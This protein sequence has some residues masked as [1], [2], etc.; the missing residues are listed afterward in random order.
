M[1]ATAMVTSATILF[2][3]EEVSSRSSTRRNES[4][5]SS[6]R[7]VNWSTAS[8]SLVSASAAAST[9]GWR[10]AQTRAPFLLLTRCYDR[11]AFPTG[12]A[13]WLTGRLPKWREA[14]TTPL[15]NLGVLAIAT[16]IC[17]LYVVSGLFKVMGE[18]WQ[19]GTALF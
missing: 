9:C 8:G 15:H 1:S 6:M 17:L 18:Q 14:V 2:T 16:Q 12:A 10:R 4:G 5:A 11:F 3:P 19:D 7:A 13:A